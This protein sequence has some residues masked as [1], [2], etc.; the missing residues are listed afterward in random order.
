M[1]NKEQQEVQ[2]FVK[3]LLKKFGVK[4]P[5]ELSKEDKKKFFDAIDKRF[6]SDDEESGK[7]VEPEDKDTLEKAKKGNLKEANRYNY[8]G[9]MLTLKDLEKKAIGKEIAF[10]GN[11]GAIKYH[12]VMTDDGKGNG[13]VFTI[14]RSQFE[15]SKLKDLTKPKTKDRYVKAILR[16]L[17]KQMPMRDGINFN[18]EVKDNPSKY[19]TTEDKIKLA[20]KMGYKI[21]GS[22]KESVSF[23]DLLE[24][25]APMRYFEIRVVNSEF[26]T[27]GDF[28]VSAETP[29][30][31]EFLARSKALEEDDL[32]VPGRTD[33]LIS[34]DSIK[35]IS[36]AEFEA[37]MFDEYDGDYEDFEDEM[38]EE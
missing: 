1:P 4:S 31:A 30:Q 26:G 18:V 6:V 17:M 2:D 35:E 28:V 27:Y 20:N 7:D 8:D 21:K 23:D 37:E 12:I 5:A 19:K 13:K 29:K 3:K 9:E 33:N 10:M 24:E 11:N 25:E 32:R 38:D 34:I 15:K 14:T 16:N 22:I 36:K